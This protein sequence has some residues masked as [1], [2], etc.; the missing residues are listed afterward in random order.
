VPYKRV[1]LHFIHVPDAISLRADLSW[2]EKAVLG[3]IAYLVKKT[4][5]T[6]AGNSYIAESTGLKEH[7]VDNIIARLKR[8]NFLYVKVYRNVYGKVWKRDF[9]VLYP[10]CLVPPRRN[11]QDS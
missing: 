3:A 4:G 9:A 5:S 6:R 10:P 2:N 11:E 7:A 8:R 1:L